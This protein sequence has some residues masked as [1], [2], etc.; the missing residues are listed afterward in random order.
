[1]LSLSRNLYVTSNQLKL[2]TWNKSG[3]VQLSEKT[4][5]VIGVGNIGKD[6]ISL[7]K[8]FDCK[9]LVN[10]IV[11]QVKY[12]ADN[13]L[14][15][16][17]KEDIF[18]NSDFITIH[19]PLNDETKN[20][21]NTQTLGLMKETAFVI[22]TARGGIFNQDDLKEALLSNKIAGAAMDVYDQE[23]PTDQDL[24]A[25]PNLMNTPH[26]G[27]NAKEAVKAMGEAAIENVVSFFNDYK[28]ISD[29]SEY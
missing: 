8:P 26:I 5:G 6:L 15:L 12:Y 29:E 16:V 17:S 1:M 13:N 7:L 18:K 22:N 9:I 27:G 20:L 2:N 28:T 3:G 10:D 11:N 14:K 24:L 23:P 4:V 19:T 21:I 25:I